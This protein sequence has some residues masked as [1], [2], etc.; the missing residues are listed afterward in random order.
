MLS[1]QVQYQGKAGILNWIFKMVFLEILASV[2]QADF[3]L[4]VTLWNSHVK[5]SIFNFRIVY[6]ECQT[7]QLNVSMQ[8]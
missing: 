3:I 5:N 4:I 1:E 2:N 6:Q 7:L 8:E